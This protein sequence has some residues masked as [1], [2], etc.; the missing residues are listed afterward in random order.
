[1]STIHADKYH[2]D[3][4]VQDVE[5]LRKEENDQTNGALVKQMIEKL[6]ANVGQVAIPTAI[7]KMFVK[8]NSAHMAQIQ[9]IVKN[10]QGNAFSPEQLKQLQD[11]NAIN[12]T[13]G[14]VQMEGSPYAKYL[15]EIAGALGALQ[16][17][18]SAKAKAKESDQ[19][20]D[21]LTK[22]IYH[23]QN[24]GSFKSIAPAL[25][26]GTLRSG[27]NAAATVSAGSWLHDMATTGQLSALTNGSLAASN[28]GMMAAGLTG[29]I[30]GLGNATGWVGSKA[31]GTA[32]W[33]AGEGKTGGML[34][35][36]AA[37]LSNL[38]P[39]VAAVMGTLTMVGTS[40]GAK[41]MMDSILKNSPLAGGQRKN[42]WNLSHALVRASDNPIAMAN[43][44]QAN[45]QIRTMMNQNALTN[46]ES[47]MLSKL[48]EIAY[49]SSMNEQ[50]H[51]ILA[52]K[53]LNSKNATTNALNKIDKDPNRDMTGIEK[54]DL[55][56][57]GK[58]SGFAEGY[59]KHAE[60]LKYVFDSFSVANIYKA[61]T[62]QDT[63]PGQFKLRDALNH[64]DPEAA[65]KKFAT[66]H[67]ITLS[68]VDLIHGNILQKIQAAD[69]SYEGRMLAA[70]VYSAMLLQSIF[71]NDLKR[72][73]N[74]GVIGELARM[75]KEQEAEY[76]KKQTMLV[77]MTIKPIMQ[78]LSKIPILSA[79]VPMLHGAAYLGKT[80]TNG[81]SGTSEFLGNLASSQG[82]TRIKDSISGYFGDMKSRVI[83]GMKTDEIKN[84]SSMRERLKAN[85]LSLQ[86]QAYMYIARQLPQDMQKIQWL[87]GSTEKAKVQDRYTG[88][89]VEQE[90]LN[91]RYREK[92]IGLRRA[93]GETNEAED[94]F[95]EAKN[96]FTKKLFK[97]SANDIRNSTEKD[98]AYYNNLLKEFETP[99][100][101]LNQSNDIQFRMSQ[102]PG[103]SNTNTNNINNQITNSNGNQ[104]AWYYQMMYQYTQMMHRYIPL[105]EEI[106]DCVCKGS[107]GDDCDCKKPKDR[108][109]SGA[110]SNKQKKLTSGTSQSPNP[111]LPAVQRDLIDTDIIDDDPN[112]PNSLSGQP[113]RKLLGSKAGKLSKLARLSRLSRLSSGKPKGSLNS[114]SLFQL[115]PEELALQNRGSNNSDSSNNTTNGIFNKRAQDDRVHK[116][117]EVFF[118]NVPYLKKL[119]DVLRP[120]KA[121]ISG[122]HGSDE[123]KN[124][125]SSDGDTNVGYYSGGDKDKNKPKGPKTSGAKP[126]MMA[127][128]VEGLKGF[129]K[130]LPKYALSAAMLMPTEM[131][132]GVA[133]SVASVI[134]GGGLAGL[135]TGAAL[136]AG[137]GFAV[138]QLFFDGKYTDKIT[139]WLGGG[140]GSGIEKVQKDSKQV[141][142]E[143]AGKGSMQDK[144]RYLDD[145][146]KTADISPKEVENQKR[147][148]IQ[149][150]DEA[151]KNKWGY[152]LTPEEVSKHKEDFNNMD[153]KT[154][155]EYFK[156]VNSTSADRNRSGIY[157]KDELDKFQEISKQISD[158]FAERIKQ[159]SIKNNDPKQNED[160]TN[161]L[162]KMNETVITN[163]K[164]MEALV[165][166][167]AE[168]SKVIVGSISDTINN[169]AKTTKN[170]GDSLALTARLNVKPQVYNLDPQ[171]LSLIPSLD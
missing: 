139:K 147:R 136:I 171:V 148:L 100:Q 137:V 116:F 87:L 88:E 51:D 146:Q 161:Q 156:D 106:R 5:D 26:A 143:L 112:Q 19:I 79:T 86:D 153:A 3:Q 141:T 105:L 41:K 55:F 142:N 117:F 94:V 121:I 149:E 9:D 96:W 21:Q 18:A 89:F 85:A 74:G 71:S 104:Q 54:K 73:S 102:G 36:G 52:N 28:P 6:N 150:Q 27:M 20:T 119:F 162:Q 69:S 157:K 64:G 140:D 16:T 25:G 130:T 118:E 107:K 98:Y 76:M 17:A 82:R 152:Y 23:M 12:K 108:N 58:L 7:T 97:I 32:A 61:F 158:I 59:L 40:I 80:I 24:G 31:L 99:D 92:S 126:S 110:L 1:M 67:G 57:N 8:Q 65:K 151:K 169:V 33:V 49:Y 166:T 127:K 111:N 133:T 66:K 15:G 109:T 47:Q 44:V 22:A 128:S 145:Q 95:D 60:G 70:N 62:G 13:T 170:V 46:A 72:D 2:R 90:E 35:K 103:G 138:D 165:Q 11:I 68:D 144:F 167:Q 37:A 50:I 125:S 114:L 124:N 45:N 38:D 14:Q 34:A 164:T 93:R 42:R 39:T 160:L 115:S 168:T 84:E 63:A 43:Y 120:K 30:A 53:G 129:A 10:T 75:Q 83:D 78:A 29:G 163:Q 154:R 155:A 113:S 91:R 134:I 81:I 122:I 131:I 101:K 135:L 4:R 159:D 123:D 56:R 48:A 77:D 132:A